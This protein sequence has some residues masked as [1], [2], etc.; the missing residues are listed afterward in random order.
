VGLWGIAL[1]A[2]APAL[3]G[4][5]LVAGLLVAGADQVEGGSFRQQE[6]A[7]GQRELKVALRPGVSLLQAAARAPQAISA[8]HGAARH[9][10]NLSRLDGDYLS[11]VSSGLLGDAH[12]VLLPGPL[13]ALEVRLEVRPEPDVAEPAPDVASA[14]GPDCLRVG[15]LPSVVGAYQQGSRLLLLRADGQFVLTDGPAAGPSGRYT[16]RCQGLQLV[17]EGGQPQ[18]L[19]PLGRDGWR[20][21]GGAVFLPLTEKPHGDVP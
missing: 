3:P 4:C 16:L 20:D 19:L 11:A 13:G 18:L 5:N 21:R 14:A 17:A 9:L 2:L 7:H 10:G 15:M 12:G 1:L 6:A 8:L